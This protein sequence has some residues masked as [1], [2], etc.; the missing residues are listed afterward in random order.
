M[1]APVRGTIIRK[2]KANATNSRQLRL[3]Q[4]ILLF[5]QRQRDGTET[6]I[7]DVAIKKGFGKGEI[8]SYKMNWRSVSN[9]FAPIIYS[10][11]F[12]YG[13]TVGKKALPF[14]SAMALTLLS[15]VVLSVGMAMSKGEA[16]G[17]VID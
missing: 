9:M 17:V 10:R 5:G 15:E 6:L 1:S 11:S 7:T 3:V 14:Y 16:H 8:E 4:L 13:K 2:P 12:S